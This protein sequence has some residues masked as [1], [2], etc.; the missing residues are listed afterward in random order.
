MPLVGSNTGFVVWRDDDKGSTVVSVVDNLNKNGSVRFVCGVFNHFRTLIL[1][2]CTDCCL[3]VCLFFFF[4][5]IRAGRHVGSF[6]YK[7]KPISL[8][9]RDAE[10]DLFSL[11]PAERN[12][13]MLYSLLSVFENGQV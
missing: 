2:Q 8:Y 10:V 4:L 1:P 5:S 12:S 6:F 13:L 3:F 11:V 7:N 9:L